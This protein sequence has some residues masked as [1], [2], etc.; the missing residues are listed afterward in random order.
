MSDFSKSSA[1]KDL[2]KLGKGFSQASDAAAQDTKKPYADG[3]LSYHKGGE[4][5]ADGT[6]KLKAGE[7]VLTAA[8]AAK[9]RKHALMV[10]GMKSLAKAASKTK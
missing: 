8:E 10:S 6:Y 1:G 9:A 3:A 2:A 7:H 4:I 5:P